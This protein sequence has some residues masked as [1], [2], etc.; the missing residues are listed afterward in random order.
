MGQQVLN[1]F[2]FFYYMKDRFSRPL[3]CTNTVSSALW[4]YVSPLGCQWPP[5]KVTFG[6]IVIT[7]KQPFPKGPRR[8]PCTFQAQGFVVLRP[9]PN[10]QF[11]M[12]AT[13]IYRSAAKE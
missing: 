9:G 8:A 13:K 11:I 1:S 5:P 12:V 4:A 6:F 2:T 3:N 7:L 10:C